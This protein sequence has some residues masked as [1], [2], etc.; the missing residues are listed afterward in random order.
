MEDLTIIYYTSNLLDTAN[1]YFLSNTKKQL[2]SAIG[3]LPMIAVSHK[4][5]EKFNKGEYTNIVLGDIGRSHL[6]LYKQILI[7]C[8]VAKTKWVAMAEDDILYSEQH[9]NFQYWVRNSTIL[10]GTYYLYDMNKLSLFTWARPPIFSFRTKRKVVNQLIAPRQL[11]IDNL[12]ERFNKIPELLKSG[13]EMARILK[14][15]GDPGRY[16]KYMGLEERKTYE[17]YSWTPSIVFSH[18]H[19]FGYLNQGNRKKQGDLR[20]VEM[21]DWG[22]ASDILKLYDKNYV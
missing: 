14:Y 7:G 20:I 3:N 9:F 8:K 13:W 12:E 22:K 19:A 2:A 6:N 16:D 4:P 11:L 10:N 21:V 1:S 15:W 5:V 18:E 17:F